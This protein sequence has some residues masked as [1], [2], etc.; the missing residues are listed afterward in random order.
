MPP[1]FCCRCVPVLTAG[2]R[3]RACVRGT[4]MI[5]MIQNEIMDRGAPVMFSDIAG[6]LRVSHL[7]D[8]H[9]LLLLLLLLSC[10]VASG[11]V[12]RRCVRLTIATQGSSTRRRAWRK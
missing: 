7:S 4:Q 12:R 2:A 1:L 9:S 3:V 10:C 8:L 11:A 5:E 6:S